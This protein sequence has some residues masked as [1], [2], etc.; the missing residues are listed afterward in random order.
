MGADLFLLGPHATDA[1]YLFDE[2]G[3]DG[4]G[5]PDNDVL[6]DC[7]AFEQRQVLKGPGHAEPG[8]IVGWD[9]RELLSANPNLPAIR[10]VDAADD[11]D[12]R[13]FSR[14][15]WPDDR[16]D[17]A[18]RH[19]RSTSNRA[20]TPP[21]DSVTPCSARASGSPRHCASQLIASP[22]QSRA[23]TGAGSTA[24]ERSFMTRFVPDKTRTSLGRNARSG[25]LRFQFANQRDDLSAELLDFLLEMQESE[26]DQVG[27]RVFERQDAFGYLPRGSDQ[28]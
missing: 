8:E 16:A 14:P 5:T 9:C 1:Q 7:Q 24:A 3:S 21:K 23:T 6:P 20:V 13:A 10:P 22:T 11:V 28:V 12:D 27:A 2:A 17:F 26:Q 4:G 18:R 19:A 25:L 15:I